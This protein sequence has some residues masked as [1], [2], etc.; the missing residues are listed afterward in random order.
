MLWEHYLLYGTLFKEIISTITLL[1]LVRIGFVTIEELEV[2]APLIMKT[3][4]FLTLGQVG[5]YSL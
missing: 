5:P 4:D 3:L 2:G 1:G